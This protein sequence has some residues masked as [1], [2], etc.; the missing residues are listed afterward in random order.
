MK[1]LL[2]QSQYLLLAATVSALKPFPA[3]RDIKRQE[4]VVISSTAIEGDITAH[5]T[6]SYYGLDAPQLSAVNSTS[7][8]W[9][10]F[11]AVSTDL[12]SSLVIVFYTALVSAF[13][14]LPVST[15]VTTVGIYVGFP[16]GTTSSTYLNAEDA[17]VKPSQQGSS[18]VYQGTGAS[19]TGTGD[20][21]EYIVTIDSSATGICGTFTLKSTA[22]AHYPC[23]PVEPGQNLQVGPNIGW[24]NAVPD[25][26]GV[27]DFTFGDSELAFTGVAYH[28]KAGF[29][30]NSLLSLLI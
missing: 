5:F 21:S 29:L 11:D 8:D 23:G 22:P 27:V 19:W 16:N 12:K 26:V 30:P 10:Y 24:S 9:W 20:D 6:S 25:A 7:F 3:I 17:I 2:T 13:P 28:D 14:F 15:D 4:P 18:G 1:F